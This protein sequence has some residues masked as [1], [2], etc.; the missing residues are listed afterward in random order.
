MLFVVEQ[1]IN[2]LQLGVTLFLVVAGLTLV[3]GV[4]NVANMAHGSFYMVG[5][6]RLPVCC[7]VQRLLRS[8]DACRDHGDVSDRARS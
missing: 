6:L 4:M 3:F 5:D 2:G 7:V 8:G 1:S